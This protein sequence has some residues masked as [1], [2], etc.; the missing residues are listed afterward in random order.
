MIYFLDNIKQ[1]YGK[2][3]DILNPFGKYFLQTIWKLYRKYL[4]SSFQYIFKHV[5]DGFV[6]NLLENITLHAK[7]IVNY[8]WQIYDKFI[9]K[10]G[11]LNV[12]YI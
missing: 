7:N 4:P 2:F 6:T 9:W 1:G 8:L 11:K 12:K 5:Y 3:M 10:T